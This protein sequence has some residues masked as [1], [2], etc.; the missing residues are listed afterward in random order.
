MPQYINNGTRTIYLLGPD[1]A[2][3]T[4]VPGKP[5]NLSEYFEI[6]VRKSKIARVTGDQPPKYQQKQNLLP[7]QSR[8]PQPVQVKRIAAVKPVRTTNIVRE[9]APVPKQHV[10]PRM[11][12]VAP[13]KR[14]LAVDVVTVR[15]QTRPTVGKIIDTNAVNHLNDI[16]AINKYPISNGVGVGILSYNRYASLKRLIDSIRRYTNLS[17]TTV[18]ISDDNSTDPATIEYLNE[19]S[20]TGEFVV[21]MNKTRAGIAGNSNRLL[22]CLERFD[23]GL[24][25]NDDVEVRAVGWD[26]FYKIATQKS[27]VHH[28]CYRE[29]GVYGASFGTPISINGLNLKFVKDRPHGAILS[30][31]CD[32]LQRVGYFDESFGIYGFE[33]VDWSHRMQ[34]YNP[35]PGY[36]DVNGSNEYFKI[37]KEESIV[38]GRKD[39]YQRA[40]AVWDSVRGTDRSNITTKHKVSGISYV[41]PYRD[42]GRSDSIIDVINNIRAQRFPVIEIIVSEHDE[43]RKF[44]VVSARHI[45][46]TKAGSG[47]FNKAHAFNKGVFHARHNKVVLHDADMLVP[48][49]YTN[50][51][52]GILNS[53]EACHIG[54][55][56]VYLNKEPSEA[57]HKDLRVIPDMAAGRVV[58]YYEGGTL[59]CTKAA[60]IKVGGFNEAF[61]GY[62][63]EDCEFYERLSQNTK[64]FGERSKHLIHLWHPRSVEWNDCHIAN[65]QLNRMLQQRPMALRISDLK[66]RLIT[67]GYI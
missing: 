50:E 15:P 56:V 1:G 35:A 59:A 5:E 67:D 65:T 4:M 37:H 48:A 22:Q 51:V 52:D 11:R 6:Y 63:V 36:F 44:P 23:Y 39:H 32:V 43:I 45:L 33:H 49:E 42:I 19:L 17:N 20:K 53:F 12:S 55:T 7:V 54:K 8:R 40:Q 26:S 47:P 64:W 34:E 46:N 13:H 24:L 9:A 61:V 66:Q 58:G 38:A 28:F 3:I 10:S 18:F 27:A 41:V 29:P 2:R 21:L 16:V 57:V 31:T 25:L 62:G 14:K 30:F 60:Y